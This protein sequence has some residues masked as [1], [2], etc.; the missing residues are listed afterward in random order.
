M[1]KIAVITGSTRP[2]RNGIKVA[3][4]A[5]DLTKKRTDAQ[6]EL[7]DILD[8]SLPLFDE[9][10]LPATGRY[11]R[12]HTK[13][14]SAKINEFDAYIFVTPEYNHSTSAALKNAID[15]LYNEWTN[16]AAGFIGYGGSGA[17]RAIEHLRGVMATLQIA[18][19]RAQVSL[20]LHG[21]FENGE[22]KN[23]EHHEKNLNQLIDQLISW[24]EALKNTRKK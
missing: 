23:S 14:W 5:F 11:I 9:P 22:V 6:F 15:F 13:K 8:Y 21:D 17:S 16:K 19:V 10:E 3:Q 20:N 18:D 1:I 4:W 2:K 12:E 24:G 7:V